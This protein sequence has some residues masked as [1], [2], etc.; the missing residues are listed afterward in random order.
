MKWKTTLALIGLTVGIGAYLSLY[1]LKQPSPEDRERLSKRVFNVSDDAITQLIVEFPETMVTLTRTQAAWRLEPIGARADETLVAQLLSELSFLTASRILSPS[2]ERP[3]DRKAFGLEP[4]TGRLTFVAEGVSTTLFFGAPTA[5]GANR[6]LNVSTREEVFVVPA[7]LFDVANTPRE[8][9]RDPLLV[10]LNPWMTDEV[11]V[12]SATATLTVSRTE[13]RWRL[14]HPLADAADSTAVNVLLNRVGALRIARFVDDAP[15]VE[16]IAEWGFDQPRAALRVA[17]RNSG[18]EAVT[19]FFGRPLPDEPSLLYAKRS[20][21]LFLYAVAAGDV[22]ALLSDPHG[23]RAKACFE[24][25]TSHVTKAA[26][27]SQQASW[28][29]ERSGES[30]RLHGSEAPL[31]AKR[32]EAFLSTLADVRVAGFVDDAPSDLEPYGLATPEGTIAIWTN[33]RESPQRLLIGAAIDGSKNR[34]GRIEGRSAVVRLPELLSDLMATDPR[35]FRLEAQPSATEA[36]T[37][38][39]DPPN[40]L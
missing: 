1:E 31:D 39:A 15:Q 11:S 34:Y 35:T 18:Q 36:A 28:S 10:R 25:F 30:W 16:G 19:I 4:P 5:V 3:L 33:D 14:T 26:V 29:I 7:G 27:T 13:N 37:P 32:I 8:A 24:L 6:Y 38:P 2:A 20:D 9:F 40:S 22:E 17:Q 21:E 23:L 12:T